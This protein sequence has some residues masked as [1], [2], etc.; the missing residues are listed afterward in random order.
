MTKLIISDID[1][2]L[3]KDGS[4]KINE[5]Y[6]EVITKLR[7]KGYL[8]TA[9][10][11]RQYASIRNM[12][13]PIA[14][15]MIFVAENGAYVVCRGR[16]ISVTPMPED[17]IL[18]L[19]ADIKSFP[20]CEVTVSTTDRLHIDSQDAY[21]IDW[22]VNGYHNEVNI[23]PDVSKVTGEVIKISLFCKE[24]VPTEAEALI[25][26]KW[27]A[28]LKVANAGKEWL[29][30]MALTVDKGHA[31]Q[32]I[33]EALNIR[34]E[35]TIAFGDNMNDIG[36]LENAGE[37]YAVATAREEVKKV[38]KHLAGSYH[39]EGVLQILQ[40]FLEEDALEISRI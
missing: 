34:K 12:F 23:V 9:A 13:E 5:A 15:D 8:F 21:F 16:E 20:N 40:S 4:G 10:S 3:V 31:L 14:E 2:T 35:D 7:E 26:T 1:G 30:C 25:K 32:S 6:Y 37:S 19:I 29:D 36:M 28:K 33:Q 22:L 18:E 17:T 24:G 38:A 11:G 39:D 27:D